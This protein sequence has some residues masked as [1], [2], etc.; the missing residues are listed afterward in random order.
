MSTSRFLAVSYTLSP[1]SSVPVKKHTE[2]DE[3]DDED[4]GEDDDEDDDEDCNEDDDCRN[5][6]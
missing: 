2:F 5:S 1:C 4:E 3:G 6:R